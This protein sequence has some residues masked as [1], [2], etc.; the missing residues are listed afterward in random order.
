MMCLYMQCFSTLG[1]CT[2]YS[3]TCAANPGRFLTLPCVVLSCPAL[4][5]PALPFA[6]PNSLKE[7]KHRSAC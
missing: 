7:R 6:R 4:P 2:T 3:R 5:C 1:K